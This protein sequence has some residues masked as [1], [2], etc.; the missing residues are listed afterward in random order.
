MISLGIFLRVYFV[1]W[2]NER[3]MESVDLWWC[4]ELAVIYPAE[5]IEAPDPGGIPLPSIE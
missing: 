1:V 4:D 3:E 2:D 5:C